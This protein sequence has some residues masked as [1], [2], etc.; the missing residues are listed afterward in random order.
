MYIQNSI[1][2]AGIFVLVVC[3]GCAVTAPQSMQYA[4]SWVNQPYEDVLFNVGRP[5]AIYDD[6]HGGRALV[7]DSISMSR[8]DGVSA[9]SDSLET[10]EQVVWYSNQRST[11]PNRMAQTHDLLFV[12]REGLIY[13]IQSNQGSRVVREQVELNVVYAGI[14]SGL[15]LLLILVSTD[16]AAWVN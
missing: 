11:V 6:G 8:S 10:Y 12:D 15:V 4:A 13:S 2:I 7:Y 1:K 16:G 9:P 5:T 3:S 14:I